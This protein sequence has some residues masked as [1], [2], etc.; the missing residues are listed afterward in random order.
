MNE[1]AQ[2]LEKAKTMS[3]ERQEET[4]N[5]ARNHN[6]FELYQVQSKAKEQYD[7]YLKLYASKIVSK[8]ESADLNKDR[9]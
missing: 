9:M 6:I 8:M 2:R 1:I 5:K 7:D 3:K 4:V